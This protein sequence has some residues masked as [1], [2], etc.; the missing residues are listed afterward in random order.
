MK[1]ALLGNMNNNNFSIM[2]YFRDLG[3][4]AHLILFKNDGYGSNAHFSPENDTWEIER[5]SPY[6]HNTAIF[7][8]DASILGRKFPTNILYFLLKS[9][10][11]LVNN[12]HGIVY[13]SVSTSDIKKCIEGYDKFVGSG[14]SGALLARIGKSLDIFYPY[15]TGIEFLGAMPIRQALKGSNFLKRY[16]IRKVACAQEASL[17][18]T[19]ICT[20]GELSLTKQTYD[21]IGVSF[22]PLNIP[23]VYNREKVPLTKDLNEKIK[24]IKTEVESCDFSIF[25]HSRQ[26]WVNSGEYLDVE[27]EL[28]SKHNEWL[29]RAFAEFIS[30]RPVKNCRVFV[31]DYGPDVGASKSLCAQLGIEE[32]VVWL[33]KMSRKDIMLLVSSCDIGV[34]E[35]YTDEGIIWGGTG[36]EVLAA[37]KPLLQGFNFKEGEFERSFGYP[38][39]PMLPVKEEKEILIHLLDMYDNPHKAK[40]IGK[41][42]AEWFNKY[43]GIS[44]ARKWLEL[45]EI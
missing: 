41:G 42:A 29:F 24:N 44:L 8:G 15:G 31:L 5:W 14:L 21:E 4:D 6:I 35:F 12:K 23:M 38:P 33:P 27:W 43:N 9:R 37:G 20:T 28:R 16:L 39:P 22:I 26:A 17:K 25:S 32:Q 1:V 45:I 30:Q 36:W 34:G 13:Q 40:S 3:V 7:N 19:R 10:I 18:Q 11:S 2:R